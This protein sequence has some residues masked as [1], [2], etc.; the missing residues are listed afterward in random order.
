MSRDPV[1]AQLQCSSVRTIA[2]QMTIVCASAG[3]HGLAI[4]S[5]ARVSGTR[6]VNFLTTAVPERFAVALRAIGA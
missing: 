2:G 4:A 6:A 5:G 1:P 3:N